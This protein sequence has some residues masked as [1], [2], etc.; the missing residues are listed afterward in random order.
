[1]VD[2]P[3]ATSL[4]TIRRR[5]LSS[6]TNVAATLGYTG[7]YTAINQAQG[8]M[9]A[10]PDVGQVINQGQVLYAVNGVPVA[11]LY[12]ST[13]V[14]RTLAAGASASDVSGPDVAELNANLVALGYATRS[15]LDPASDQ[16]NWQTRRAVQKL[17]AHLGVKQTGSLSL[18]DV[19]FLP[20]AARVTT[21]SATLGGPAG[22]G[23]PVLTATS[24]TRQVTISLDAAQQSQVKVGD[25]VTIMLPTHQTTPGVVASVG[26]V[27]VSAAS[28]GSGGP[29]VTVKVT[30]TDPAATGSLDQAPVQVSIITAKVQDALVVPVTALVALSGGGY[31][32]EVVGGDG[33]RRLV[34]VTM[35]LVDDGDGLV[36][37]TG[38]GLAAGQSVVVPGS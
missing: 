4:A 29:T 26:T 17:Q 5:A 28:G 37:V 3:V 19:V 20:S 21:V 34:P 36:E 18:G 16:F 30:P 23:Q 24:T 38:S 31:A 2:N 8:T 7:G 10:L 13:P 11:L 6:Q 25:P 33:G 35:G 22:P 27:A 32:V 9:T 1:V 15:E 12:G 14:F